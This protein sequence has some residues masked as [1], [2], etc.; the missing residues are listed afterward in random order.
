MTFVATRR[1]NSVRYFLRFRV[2]ENALLMA[3][4]RITFSLRL[5]WEG[6]F[7]IKHLSVPRYIQT[8]D[9]KVRFELSVKPMAR[10]TTRTKSTTSTQGQSPCAEWFRCCSDLNGRVSTGFVPDL[11]SCLGLWTFSSFAFLLHAFRVKCHNASYHARLY[12][13]LTQNRHSGGSR[14]DRAS[15]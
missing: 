9:L 6:Q 8:D 10:T 15:Q 3:M 7:Q 12:F 1:F 4:T 5:M 13:C 14:R 2:Q 11:S